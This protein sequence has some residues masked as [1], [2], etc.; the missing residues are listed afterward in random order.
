MFNFQKI[1]KYLKTSKNVLFSKKSRK[2]KNNLFSKNIL[3]NIKKYFI[4]QKMPK[5]QK[6]AKNS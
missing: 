6:K 3:K 4:F 2:I 5:I 1:E